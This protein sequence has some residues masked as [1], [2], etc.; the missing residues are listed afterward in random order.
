MI[1][2]S[3]VTFDVGS[4]RLLISTSTMKALNAIEIP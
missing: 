4:I 3:H 1:I 2:T